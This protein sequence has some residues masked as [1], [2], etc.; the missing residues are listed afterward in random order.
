MTPRPKLF[1]DNHDPARNP[2]YGHEVSV[3]IVA[4]TDTRISR[5]TPPGLRVDARAL[6]S[7]RGFS[8]VDFGHA[9]ADALVDLFWHAS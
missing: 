6:L 1:A 8:P 5:A 2:F 9:A 3:S 4:Q 7:V